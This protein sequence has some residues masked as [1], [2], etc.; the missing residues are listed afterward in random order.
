ML[1][2]VLKVVAGALFFVACT[3]TKPEEYWENLEVVSRLDG[4]NANI[5]Y[6]YVFGGVEE[7]TTKINDTIRCFYTSWIV[8]ADKS[9]SID[10]TLTLLRQEKKAD[11]VIAHIEY[12][13][14]GNGSFFIKGDTA[15]VLCEKEYYMG[16]A[17]FMI[18]KAYLNFDS[19]TGE[20]I[21]NKSLI[22]DS[23]QVK[24]LIASYLKGNY[25]DVDGYSQFFNNINLEELPLPE[26]IGMD[27]LGYVFIYNVYEIAPRSTGVIQFG[28][29][30]E[31]VDSKAKI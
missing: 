6:P 1:S 10:S 14:L 23:L 11:S 27:S 16:G 8:D 19:N 20:L 28:I 26:A 21:S 25:P 18:E 22:K 7:V 4:V 31:M 2:R 17:N 5:S 9:C 24:A 3:T 13:L 15:S 12:E 29:P 30:Y